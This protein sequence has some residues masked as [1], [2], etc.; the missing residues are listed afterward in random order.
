MKVGILGSGD[1]ARSLAKGFLA[2]G[3]GVRLG[4][5]SGQ[6]E[7]LAQ[8]I[9]AEKLSVSQGTFGATAEWGEM[10]VVATHGM[11]TELVVRSAGVDH[12]AG[13]VVIDVTNPL[14][15]R[16]DG[17]PT[18]GI[19]G[20]DSAGEQLQRILPDAHVVK[21]FNIIGDTSFFRPDFPDGPPDMFI[22]GN[23]RRCEID[24]DA[25]SPRLRVDVGDRHRRDRGVARARVAVHPLGEVGDGPREPLDRLPPPPKVSPPARGEKPRRGGHER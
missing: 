20:G 1:V 25:A 7:E 9:S 4:S 11:T 6:K 17:P 3:H 5:R 19:S 18:L 21:A 14:L 13:K 8:W 2:T 12:F 16:P 22:C 15:M 24:G 10:V 23:E